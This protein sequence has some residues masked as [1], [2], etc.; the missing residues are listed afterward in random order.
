LPEATTEQTDS[1]TRVLG[2]VAAERTRQDAKYGPEVLEHGTGGMAR[3]AIRD[4][5]QRITATA[6]SAGTVTRGQI[7][8]TECAEALAE[9]DP[10]A[11]REELV[12]VAASAVA[13]VQQLDDE[14]ILQRQ[15]LR[16]DQDEDEA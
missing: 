10:I 11:L 3:I 6:T 2:D 16:Q 12:Q 9:E 8:Q 7:L 4:R 13:F 14:A 15:R 5:L 1:L